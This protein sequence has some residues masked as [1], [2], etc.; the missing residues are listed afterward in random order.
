MGRGSP[1]HRRACLTAFMTAKSTDH[2]CEVVA[3]PLWQAMCRRMSSYF[4]TTADMAFDG[5]LRRGFRG[6]CPASSMHRTVLRRVAA[7]G[8]L[9][10]SGFRNRRIVVVAIEVLGCGVQAQH[11]RCS[12]R[13]LPGPAP[14]AR[15][16]SLFQSG[17]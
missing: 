5:V 9:P 11:P 12:S 4:T 16:A 7:V 15:G 3:S 6:L 17:R 8:V 14:V 13:S 10:P 1:A 2:K